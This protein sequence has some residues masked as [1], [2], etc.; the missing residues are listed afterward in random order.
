MKHLAILQKQ[1]TALIII[2]MQEKFAPAIP[3]FAAI[4]ANITKL[5]LGF[6]LFKIPCIVTE[7]YPQGLGPT[8]EPIKQMFP[9]LE[10]IEKNEFACTDNTDFW[11][12]VNPLHIETFVVCGVESHV[13]INQTV[14]GLIAKKHTVH[15]VADAIG[16]RKNLDHD[17]ANP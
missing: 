12:A 13:C 15:V 16:S 17:L 8:V 10:I 3:S 11:K 14:L 7:Q 1:K 9:I 5:I 6:Q 2:D 4:T